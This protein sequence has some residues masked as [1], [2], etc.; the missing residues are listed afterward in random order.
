MELSAMRLYINSWAG[1]ERAGGR[2][3]GREGESTK[4]RAE[5]GRDKRTR[6]RD[7]VERR[8]MVERGCSAV[9]NVYVYMYKLYKERY[10]PH[11]VLN[12]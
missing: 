1:G 12:C 5:R 11:L 8:R 7:R 4:E 10:K 2:E 9:I 6:E 3:R